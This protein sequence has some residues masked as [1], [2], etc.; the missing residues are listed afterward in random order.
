M[1]K[2][3]CIEN[4]TPQEISSALRA[5]NNPIR[6][7]CQLCYLQQANI[8]GYNHTT[9]AGIFCDQMLLLDAADMLDKQIQNSSYTENTIR[10]AIIMLTPTIEGN[11]AVD[12]ARKLLEGI[13]MKKREN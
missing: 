1:S 2:E 5:C 11:R 6:P 4:P 10:A 7:Q 12:R 8:V 13:V 9:S 3:K